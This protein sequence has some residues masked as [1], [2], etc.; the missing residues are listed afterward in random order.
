ME[1][2]NIEQE[3]TEKVAPL[4]VWKSRGYNRCIADGYRLFAD[5]FSSI[6]R[7][8][9]MPLA[10][11]ALFVA[12][13]MVL[14]FNGVNNQMTGLSTYNPAMVQKGSVMIIASWVASLLSLVAMNIMYGRYFTMLR[15][16]S[17]TDRMPMKKEKL[18][19]SDVR[20]MVRRV[21]IA[22]IAFI[23][24]FAIAIAITAAPLKI[25]YSGI[26]GDPS[27]YALYGISLVLALV[28]F[29]LILPIYNVYMSY[30]ID[31]SKGL[32]KTLTT[33]YGKSLRHWGML[34]AIFIVT[35]IILA[36]IMVVLAL[37]LMILM[38]ADNINTLGMSQGDPSGLPATFS[39][40]M[41][42]TMFV[43]TM[44]SYYIYMIVYAVMYYAYGSIETQEKER[45]EAKE[46][47]R[48]L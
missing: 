40:L 35:A 31:H 25:W 29:V 4:T 43:V 26:F 39:L 11:F 27:N 7:H 41:V 28:C 33:Q 14:G 23:I 19:K 21:W 10:L 42:I 36:M 46:R 48:Q 15:Q 9:W 24:V 17:L 30:I 22:M 18:V 3:K 8:T 16:H 2:M 20:R 37:P 34:F 12:I 45:K 44:A 1:K 13:G 38:Y 47:E 32:L 5:N 6:V